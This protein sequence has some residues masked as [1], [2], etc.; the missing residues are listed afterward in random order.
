MFSTQVF[1]I[2]SSHFANLKRQHCYLG[3]AVKLT[4]FLS[5]A[6]IIES[7]MAIRKASETVTLTINAW[8]NV[9]TRRLAMHIGR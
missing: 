7:K 5:N 1:R 9:W 8:L 3:A 2:L 4:C 6:V